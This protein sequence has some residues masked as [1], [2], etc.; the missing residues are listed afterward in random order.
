M[1]LVFWGELMIFVS[2]IANFA[3]FFLFFK[4]SVLGRFYLIV[5]LNKYYPKGKRKFI[6]GRGI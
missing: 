4:S 5:N 3:A 6:K 1:A 2:V